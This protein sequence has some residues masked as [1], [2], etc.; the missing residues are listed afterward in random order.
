MTP[1]SWS[2]W[3]AWAALFGTTLSGLYA[4]KAFSLARSHDAILRGDDVVIAGRLQKPDLHH[5]DH[6][7]CVLWTHLVNRSSRRAV[8]TKVV[9]FET[10]ARPI[11]VTWSGRISDVGNPEQS[12]GVL[13]VDIDAS[14]FLRRDDGETMR[15]G[16][17]VKITHSFSVAPLVL[18]YEEF[19]DWMDWIEK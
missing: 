18:K 11:A 6:R 7:K 5:P 9:A 16:T 1:E 10:D 13:A 14:L 19:G 15:D 4:A 17:V 12:S 2:A 8:V 3:A